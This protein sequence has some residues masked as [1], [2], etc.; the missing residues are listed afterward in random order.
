MRRQWAGDRTRLSLP[1][2]A[3]Q[4]FD[5]VMCMWALCVCATVR[6]LLPFVTRRVRTTE[7][8]FSTRRETGRRCR[9]WLLWWIKV[10]SFHL[11]PV[12]DARLR[13][14]HPLGYAESSF[15]PRRQQNC[16]LC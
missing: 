6:V 10:T 2:C 13:A 4:G 8:G 7:M 5:E 16:K 3:L 12:K 1:A 14:S 9:A 11:Q 15:L